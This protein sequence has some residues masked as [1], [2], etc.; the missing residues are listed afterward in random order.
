MF[1]RRKH[2]LNLLFSGKCYIRVRRLKI[3]II[4]KKKNVRVSGIGAKF[5]KPSGNFLEDGYFEQLFYEDS[6]FASPLFFEIL[7]IF[8]K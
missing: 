2:L 1:K 8:F 6:S 5:I 7:G 3:K 4:K